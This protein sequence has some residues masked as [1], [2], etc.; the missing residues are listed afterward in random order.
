MKAR[1]AFTYG[2]RT[3]GSLGGK[4]MPN[5][6][7][8]LRFQIRAEERRAAISIRARSPC[9][10]ASIPLDLEFSY[11]QI[12]SSSVLECPRLKLERLSR[13]LALRF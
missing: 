7:G 2:E 4:K 13:I 1:R 8:A 10:C 3:G 5:I 9:T 12:T 6:N 11:V